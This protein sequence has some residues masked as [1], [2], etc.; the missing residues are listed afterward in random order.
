M[1][2]DAALFDA[3]VEG[4]RTKLLSMASRREVFVLVG[5]D[6]LM[7]VL[8][9]VCTIYLFNVLRSHVKDRCGLLY[10]SRIT[11]ID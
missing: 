8:V 10:H 7:G 5:L 4:S 1:V 6:W 9:E 3:I 2:L 11:T